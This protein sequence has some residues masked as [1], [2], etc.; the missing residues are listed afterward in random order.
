MPIQKRPL[1][2]GRPVKDGFDGYE[3][4]ACGAHSYNS[5]KM[6]HKPG[7]PEEKKD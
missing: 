6:T 1:P 4:T 2:D 3:C 7:C 5:V